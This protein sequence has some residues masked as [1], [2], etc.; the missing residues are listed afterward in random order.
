MDKPKIKPK[1]RPPDQTLAE[2]TYLRY[3]IDQAL[4]VR[5]RLRSN[6]EFSGVIEFYDTSFI[7][8]TRTDGPNLFIFK[9]DIKYLHEEEG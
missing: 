3:L 9:H 2:V 4:P 7:R 5:V 8:L 1:S 6:E